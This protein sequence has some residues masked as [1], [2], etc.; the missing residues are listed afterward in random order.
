MTGPY[1]SELR[2]VMASEAD[3][4][5][6]QQVVERSD[7]AWLGHEWEW[8][9]LVE[10]G[11]WG[12]RSCSLLM[13]A[14]ERPVA[15][16]PLHLT[17]RNI[18]PL[19]RRILHSNFWAPAGIAL[20][21][22]VAEN[23]R[24]VVTAAAISAIHET[25]RRLRVDKIH[26]RVAPLSRRAL[27][28]LD[29]DN[30]LARYGFRD[31]STHTLVLQLAGRSETELWEGLEGRCRTAIRKA[32]REG[33]KVVRSGP[34]D[35]VDR[36][37]ELHVATYRRTG[38]RPHPRRYFEVILRSPWSVVFFAEH[39]GETIA[40]LNVGIYGDTS[41]YWTGASRQIAG[42]LGANNLLQWH[43]I[44]WL[45]AEGRSCY[46]LGELP[47]PGKSPRDDPK[48]FALAHF[49]RSFGGALNPYHRAEFVYAH[50]RELVVTRLRILR[51]ALRG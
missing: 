47:P 11:V 1:A 4:S 35:V 32:E 42:A 43:A 29:R 7:D 18:G 48:L 22:D 27:L 39:R 12:A 5:A 28:R 9:T 21:A 16:V 37:Y 23:Q 50:L 51:Y 36:Y 2:V 17:E 3:R 25:A 15:L 6:W 38:A 46:E 19:T 33:V 26:V 13:W 44:R 31:Q 34:E 30:P 24:T 45:R 8:N 20:P 41:F 40:A 49:K 10:E 14:G